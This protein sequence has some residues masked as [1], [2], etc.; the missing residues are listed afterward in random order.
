[1][2]DFGVVRNCRRCGA[3]FRDPSRTSPRSYC[4]ACVPRPH[5]EQRATRAD[6]ER[7]RNLLL[8]ALSWEG[9]NVDHSLRGDPAV[10]DADLV[11]A[12]PELS[13]AR[14]WAEEHYAHHRFVL[15]LDEDAAFESWRT[16]HEVRDLER[17][18]R[19]YAQWLSLPEPCD[20]EPGSVFDWRDKYPRAY[21]LEA[22][23]EPAP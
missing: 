1:M 13:A 17:S 19:W 21:A 12:W 22:A 8:N 16:F 15:G 6:E 14:E 18:R 9:P 7:W 11:A 20:P 2:T 5:P 3:E 10:E 23:E 4:D